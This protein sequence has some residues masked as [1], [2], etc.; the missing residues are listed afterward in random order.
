MSVRVKGSVVSLN[1]AFVGG[2]GVS[3]FHP[4]Q[5]VFDSSRDMVFPVFRF[6]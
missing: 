4:K 3:V 1:P 6:A 5:F 2:S